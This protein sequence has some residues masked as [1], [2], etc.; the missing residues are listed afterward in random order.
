MKLITLNTWGGRA[1]KEL[2]LSFFK[3][4]RDD[5]DIF[6][7]QEVFAAQ[8][9]GFDKQPTANQ[10]LDAS[11]FMN[12]GMQDIRDTLGKGYATLYHP[13]F[14][15]LFGLMMAV[16]SNTPILESGDIFVH[17]H[18]TYEPKVDT[19]NHARNIQYAKININNR[20]V[21]VI[22]F[23]GLWN[24]KGKADSEE[25]IQQS[26]KI[27]SFLEGVKGEIILSG[28]F[29]LRPDTESISILEDVGLRNMVTEHGITSTRTSYYKKEEK[30]ADYVF[31]TNG[32]DVKDFKMLPE[33]VSDHSALLLEFE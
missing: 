28:D 6:C 31:V 22:N 25:R 29:N 5:I 4:Y 26:K 21:T 7:L 2:L 13:H 32:I 11:I 17:K 18:R 27:V 3:E 1:G 10:K 23:H 19:A 14:Y 20:P 24:G 12:H 9:D 16:K 15:D 8:Y 33:E 30:F